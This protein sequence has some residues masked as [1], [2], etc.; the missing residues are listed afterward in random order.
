MTPLFILLPILLLILILLFFRVRFCLSYDGNFSLVLRYSLLRIPLYPRKAKPR[1]GTVKK[2]KTKGNE[3]GHSKKPSEKKPRTALRLG[4]V[5]FLLRVL[6]E[7]I[8]S[9]LERA[10]RHVR[11]VVRELTLTVGG[12]DD[13]ARAAIE[14]GVLSQAA[15]YLL[16]YLDNT[17]VLSP[18]KDGAVNVGVNFLGKGHTLRVRTEIACPLL[19]L[20]PLLLSSFSKALGARGRWTRYRTRAEKPKSNEALNAK[21]V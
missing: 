14:Y 13:A 9:I 11:I 16:A 8:E 1:N 5:R 10:A 12:A 4:D 3:N 15:S 7:T 2:K 21:G 20:L 18:P 6:R 17:G 19:F